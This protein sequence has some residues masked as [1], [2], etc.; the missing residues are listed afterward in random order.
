MDTEKKEFGKWWIWIL[1]LIIVSISAL[2]V[3]GYMGKWFG[4]TME[5]EIFESSYQK[6][7]ADSAK[8]KAYKA[9]LAQINVKLNSDTLDSSTRTN[10]EAQ[11]AM[12]EVQ[13]QSN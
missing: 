11:K 10:L 6:T 3:T 9:Q 13:L 1:L 12:I 5:R 7:A 8:A 2:S 4:V